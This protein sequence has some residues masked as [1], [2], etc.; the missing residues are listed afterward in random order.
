[1]KPVA[2]L[3]QL[4]DSVW[5]EHSLHDHLMHV[6]ELAGRFAKEFGNADWLQAA[7]LLHDLG[8]FNPTWQEYIR[9][10]NGDYSEEDDGQD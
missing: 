4:E 1:M 5:E 3:R 10:N 8:K 2:H 7:G 9:R 6:A